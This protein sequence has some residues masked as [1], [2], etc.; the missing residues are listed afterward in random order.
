MTVR[1]SGRADA[2]SIGRTIYRAVADDRVTA[3]APT[4]AKLHEAG[5]F[6]FPELYASARADRYSRRL[7]WRD[8]EYRFVVVGMTWGPGQF[9]PLHDHAGSWGAEIVV[10]GSM[11]QTAFRLVDRDPE[12]RFRFIREGEEI[13]HAGEVSVVLPP[14]EYHIFG[15]PTSEVSRTVHVYGC[16]FDRCQT[17]THDADGWWRS[18]TVELSYDA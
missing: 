2:A 3:L 14:L 16:A 10:E 12:G 1:T 18:Q 11:K 7:I 5:A 9:A 4:L 17:F 6:G 8:P 15:N 13:A